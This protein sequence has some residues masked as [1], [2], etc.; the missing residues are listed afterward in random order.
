MAGGSKGL[1]SFDD[2]VKFIL[3]NYGEDFCLKPEQHNALK[4]IYENGN[5]LVVNLPTGYGKSLIYF[6]LP[7]L[8]KF[9][10]ELPADHSGS[11]LVISP[12]NLIQI[13]QMQ[14]LTSQNITSCRLDVH[15]KSWAYK[16]LKQ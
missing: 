2:A 13:D 14:K 6:V 16:V 11:V 15:C 9:K 4:F 5:D 8:L 7:D 12:L 1:P 3:R 10:F